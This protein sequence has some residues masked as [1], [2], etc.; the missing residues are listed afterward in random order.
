[1]FLRH[2]LGEFHQFNQYAVGFILGREEKPKQQMS[3]KFDE[4]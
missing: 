1:M 4:L 2:G 3:M